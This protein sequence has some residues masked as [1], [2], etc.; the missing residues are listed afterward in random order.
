MRLQYGLMR[1]TSVTQMVL[2]EGRLRSLVLTPTDTGEALPVSFDQVRHVGAGDRPGS[3]MA[4]SFTLGHPV[5]ESDLEGAWRAVVERHGTLR[6]RFQDNGSHP[7]TLWRTSPGAPV[8]TSHG[9]GPEASREQLRQVL[10]ATCRPFSN[11]SHRLLTIT[12]PDD[13]TRP[14]T[15]VIGADHAHVDAWSLLALV[16]DLTA[17][18]ADRPDGRPPGATLPPAADF[19]DHTRALAARPPTPAAVLD[20]WHDIIATGGGLMPTFPLPLGR[21]DPPPEEVV[22]V[23][24][25]LDPAEVE[26][27]QAWAAERGTRMLPVAVS[28]LVRVTSELSGQ[29]LR[30]VLPV[31]S[32]Y[33]S[34]WHDSVGWF[35]TNSVLECD[36]DDLGACTRAVA[37]AIQLGSHPLERIMARYGGMPQGPGMFAMSWLDNRRLPISVPAAAGAQHVSARIRTDGVMVWFVVNDDGLHLRCRYPDTPEARRNVELWLARVRDGLRA[38]I[39]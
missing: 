1:L 33:E 21:L 39:H 9:P 34:T 11:P 38:V 5:S 17:F 18:L 12:D 6:T 36:D 10:D 2:P 25:V 16:R 13:P 31:H 7:P 32:R 23:R 14:A 8:W 22:V 4:V 20:R 30:A 3:W 29:P 26:T 28:V 24:D 35:I 27:F 37:E 19:A 15:I